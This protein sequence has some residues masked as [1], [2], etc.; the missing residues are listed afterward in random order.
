MRFLDEAATAAIAGEIE[1]PEA[2]GNAC[3][4][5]LT[6]CENVLDLDRAG[7]WQR[8][9][10]RGRTSSTDEQLGLTFCRK[11]HIN[12]LVWSGEWAQAE[13]EIERMGPRSAARDAPALGRR[14]DGA[15]RDAAAPGPTRRGARHLRRGAR[16]PALDPRP[17]RARARGGARGGGAA[18]SPSAICASSAIRCA[19][20]TF[21]RCGWWCEPPAPPVTI[22][23]AAAATASAGS[24]RGALGTDLMR[25]FAAAAR[26][27]VARARSRV[28]VRARG[29]RAGD[30]ALLRE[31]GAVR[32]RACAARSRRRCCARS[33][34]TT[35][36]T[37]KRGP[38]SLP[39]PSW[40][41]RAGVERARRACETTDRRRRA[42]SRSPRFR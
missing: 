19:P 29:S 16:A 39:S 28:R 40:A 27:L 42:P 18:R 11:H 3:C 2:R 32:G 8:R 34:T 35:P 24:A 25:A 20:I 36:P 21:R 5:V 26:G 14:E 31:P 17:R 38:R 7:Q 37:S 6:A 9:V 13:A 33:A 22:E 1:D 41:R 12:I 23:R 30:R 4:Y 10:S 15:G